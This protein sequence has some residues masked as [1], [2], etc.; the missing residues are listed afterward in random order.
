MLEAKS[1][2]YSLKKMEKEGFIKKKGLTRGKHLRKYI[3]TIT[4]KGEREFVALCGQTLAS[5]RRPF[6]DMDIALYFLPY[7][8]R[9]NIVARLRL[10][11][12]FF[13]KVKEWL[14]DKLSTKNEFP[15]HHR[16]LLKHHLNLL[17]TE[18]DFVK[19]IINAIKNK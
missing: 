12:R 9:K 8:D 2:Y 4:P 6:I 18:E 14:T 5:Q 1:I 3:Y 15:I 17:K 16:L 11:A 7:L 19:E 10:R 13:E